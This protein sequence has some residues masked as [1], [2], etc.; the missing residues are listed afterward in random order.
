MLVHARYSQTHGAAGLPLRISLVKD[1]QLTDLCL[2]TEARY[3]R[4]PAL[5]DLHAAFQDHP[6]AMEHFPSGSIIALPMSMKR[7]DAS[8]R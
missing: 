3:T 7:K 2:V 6:A 8:Q 5:A 4:H 1:L